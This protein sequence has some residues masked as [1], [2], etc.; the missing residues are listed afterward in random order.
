MLGP[1]L[2]PECEA[3]HLAWSRDRFFVCENCG[4]RVEIKG[5]PFEYLRQKAKEIEEWEQNSPCHN[6]VFINH[7]KQ[8]KQ[9]NK[10]NTWKR[11]KQQ[12]CM[13]HPII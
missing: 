1:I 11:R 12:F 7:C 3:N 5:D 4:F 9:Q 13:P 8:G 10:N 2:C 6:C